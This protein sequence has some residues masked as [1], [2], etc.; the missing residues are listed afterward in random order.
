MMEKILLRLNFKAIILS[1]NA[2]NFNNILGD[3]SGSAKFNIG[4]GKC[5]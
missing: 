1:D 5:F 2:V 4:E 3:F